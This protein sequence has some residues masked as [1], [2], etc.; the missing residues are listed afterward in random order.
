MPWESI[1][2]TIKRSDTGTVVGHS[3]TAAAAKASVRARYAN[4]NDIGQKLG[5]LMSKKAKS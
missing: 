3:K 4:S 1:G 5:R 2:K